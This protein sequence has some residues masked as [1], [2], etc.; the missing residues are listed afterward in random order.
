MSPSAPSTKSNVRVTPQTPPTKKRTL[1]QIANDDGSTAKRSRNKTGDNAK[2]SECEICGKARD[3]GQRG[4]ACQV[5]LLALRKISGHQSIE[6]CK[7]D[8]QLFEKVVSKSKELQMPAKP[9]DAPK[10]IT[11][12]DWMCRIQNCEEMLT[13]LME[14]FGLW[15]CNHCHGEASCQGNGAR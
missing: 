13:K 4:S 5:C 12:R 10:R 2:R 9:A 15:Q 1:L 7:A 11:R 6:K 8:Q 14:H 3:A